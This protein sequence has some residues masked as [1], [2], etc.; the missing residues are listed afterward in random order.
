MPMP[1][2]WIARIAKAEREKQIVAMCDDGA[3]YVDVA[4][5][6]G[7]HGSA[8]VS[9]IYDRRKRMRIGRYHEVNY[10]VSR[11]ITRSDLVGRRAR[12]HRQRKRS[13]PSFACG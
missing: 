6:F 8:T 10:R 9:D 7:L 11:L 2:D 13:L 1:K 3:T 12:H 5:H 4:R